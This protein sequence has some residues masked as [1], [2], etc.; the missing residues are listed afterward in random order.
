MSKAK[1]GK[2]ARAA[3]V[4]YMFDELKRKRVTPS[5]CS[6]LQIQLAADRLCGAEFDR[7]A[8]AIVAQLG[9]I[10]VEPLTTPS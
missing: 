7:L 5:V 10:T 9:P 1:A 4:S 2:V 8:A 6:E 3:Y